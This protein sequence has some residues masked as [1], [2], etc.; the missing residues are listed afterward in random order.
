MRLDEAHRVLE[1]MKVE[2]FEDVDV[3]GKEDSIWLDANWVV[4]EHS[5]AAGTKEVDTDTTIKFSVGNE[6]D[7]KVLDLIPADSPFAR[8]KDAESR[9]PS[10]PTKP[11][12]KDPKITIE[13]KWESEDFPIPDEDRIATSWT[14]ADATVKVTNRSKYTLR[15]ETVE[16]NLAI[17]KPD[18]RNELEAEDY[19]DPGTLLNPNDIDEGEY[20]WY[21]DPGDTNEYQP[22]VGL[23]E[24]TDVLPLISADEPILT[25]RVTWR[26]KADK[27]FRKCTLRPA[28]TSTV[29]DRF[30]EGSGASQWPVSVERVPD[31]VNVA[32]KRCASDEDEVLDATDLTMVRGKKKIRPVADRLK[33][34]VAANK[35]RKIEVA[36]LGDI[37]EGWSLQQ[38]GDQDTP[39]VWK[40]PAAG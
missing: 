6:D 2:N 38:P 27:D 14:R 36:Y 3:V 10:K 7:R 20:G 18:K 26:Y 15:I 40:V 37:N 34:P 1:G 23:N 32:I 8:E 9:R 4:V 25:P 33:V 30:P 28:R 21:L 12:C 17:R 35:C 29:G 5:P 13:T 31:G 22:W 24:L 19:N 39:F 16:T 11:A